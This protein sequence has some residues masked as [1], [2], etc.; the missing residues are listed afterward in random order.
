[1]ASATTTVRAACWP[2]AAA[3]Q[4]LVSQ[5]RADR[6]CAG[7]LL[8]LLFVRHD[9]R[10]KDEAVNKCLYNEISGSKVLA[11]TMP[12]LGPRAHSK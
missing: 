10:C 8:Q 3:N 1:M 5:M 2:A 11:P 4:W 12:C 7:A 6:L 9:H